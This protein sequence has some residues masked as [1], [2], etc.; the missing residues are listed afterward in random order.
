MNR[1]FSESV[2]WIVTSW[3][4]LGSSFLLLLIHLYPSSLLNISTVKDSS[5]VAVQIFDQKKFK[6]RDQGFLGVINVRVAD[7]IDLELG[8]KGEF[9]SLWNG[10]LSVLRLREYRRGWK[11]S[12][13]EVWNSGRSDLSKSVELG[14]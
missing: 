6:K 1:V 12:G 11:K 14:S 7:V 9:L 10:R 13:S 8:G 5:I 2:L 4:D 3:S